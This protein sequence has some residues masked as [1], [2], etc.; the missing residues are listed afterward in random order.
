MREFK[1]FKKGINLGGWV[2]QCGEGNYTKERFDTFITEKDIEKIAG[3][4]LDHVRMPIDF[5]L[6]QND[7]MSFNESGFAYIDNCLAWCEKYGLNTVLDL[8]K[9]MGFIFDD[10]TYCQFFHNKDL[11]DNFVRVWEEFTRRYGK[12]HERVAFELLNEVT[13][14][15]YAEIWNGIAD[16]TIRA[17]RAINKDIRIIYGG[18]FNSSIDGLTLLPEPQDENIVFTFHC[19]SPL[20]FTHQSAYWI[21][22]MPAD[23][24]VAYP[25]DVQVLRR[26]SGEILGD[27]FDGD[28][29]DVTGEI[30][31]GFFERLFERAIAVGEKYNVPLYCGEYGVIDKAEPT[32]TLEWFRHINAAFEKYDIGRAV[33]T[34]KE[35]DFGI[36]DEHYAPVADE[37]IKLL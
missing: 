9:T 16:R 34:Y 23:L 7:D 28:F 32:E 8:H 27:D 24:K 13:D 25:D 18:I 20:I 12:Y 1:G 35:K 36:V 31:S 11:Q 3:W 15:D 14:R 6:F 17:I 5:H 19:Y 29:G 33:W 22:T 4:G 26:K 37:I 2:S 10:S 21:P 30:G